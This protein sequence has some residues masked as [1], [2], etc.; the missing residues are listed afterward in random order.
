VNLLALLIV[1]YLW[2]TIALFTIVFGLFVPLPGPTIVPWIVGV[3]V[4]VLVVLAFHQFT[5]RRGR[6]YYEA[7]PRKER[8]RIDRESRGKRKR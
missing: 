6:S 3:A 7:L 4:G 1:R 5:V 8:Q 2:V